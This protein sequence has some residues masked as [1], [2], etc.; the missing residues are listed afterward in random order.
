MGAARLAAVLLT[1]AV[2]TSCAPAATSVLN[3]TLGDEAALTFVTS[4]DGP[5]GDVA[6]TGLCFEPGGIEA[7]GVKLDIIASTVMHLDA[8]CE[9]ETYGA[10]CSL[11]DV[12]TPTFVQVTAEDVTATAFYRRSD[13]NRIRQEAAH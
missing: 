5:C 4:R 9:T 12:D 3:R 8:A 11:G 10:T 1:L 7:L 13:S 2:L 6:T